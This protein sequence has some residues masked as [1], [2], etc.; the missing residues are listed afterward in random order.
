MWNGGIHDYSTGFKELMAG[1][2]F[3]GFIGY[4]AVDYFFFDASIWK[5]EPAAVVEQVSTDVK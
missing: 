4:V 3:W 5:D 2:L 1:I